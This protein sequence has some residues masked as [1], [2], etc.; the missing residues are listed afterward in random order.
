[1]SSFAKNNY[2]VFDNIEELNKDDTLESSGKIG[3]EFPNELANEKYIGNHRIIWKKH[4]K[5][6]FTLGPHCI[7]LQNIIN[8]I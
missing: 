5:I 3:F 7:Y 8:L 6:I 2:V 1:M 4:R